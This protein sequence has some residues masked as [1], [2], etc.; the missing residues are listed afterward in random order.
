[1]CFRICGHLPNQTLTF[2]SKMVDLYGSYFLEVEVMLVEVV[3]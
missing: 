1:V 3:L 2:K